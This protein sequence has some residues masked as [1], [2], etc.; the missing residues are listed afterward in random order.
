MHI[1]SVRRWLFFG[2]SE[3]DC[4]NWFLVSFSESTTFRCERCRNLRLK[5][6]AVIRRTVFEAIVLGEAVFVSGVSPGAS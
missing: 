5:D 1:V 4:R 6:I 2:V 3:H